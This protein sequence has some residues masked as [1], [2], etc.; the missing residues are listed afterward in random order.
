MDLLEKFIGLNKNRNTT[1]ETHK[2]YYYYI[3]QKQGK[4]TFCYSLRDIVIYTRTDNNKNKLS[5]SVK[6]VINCKSNYNFIISPE[7][8]GN[9]SKINCIDFK[10]NQLKQVGSV[11]VNKYL[12][13]NILDCI[14][15]GYSGYAI[16][17][18]VYDN[19]DLC[20][21][22]DDLIE[23]KCMSHS[24][25]LYI[26][27][28]CN[29]CIIF[30][31]NTE[32]TLYGIEELFT[33]EPEF[34]KINR[35]LKIINKGKKMKFHL[36]NEKI[37]NIQALSKK[38][39]GQTCVLWSLY[40]FD[41]WITRKNK[42]CDYSQFYLD[43]LKPQINFI[44]AK[45]MLTFYEKF[46]EYFNYDKK[47]LIDFIE[48]MSTL[49]IDQKKLYNEN[50]LEIKDFLKLNKNKWA[51]QYMIYD[52]T[53]MYTYLLFK[54][55]INTT[56]FVSFYYNYELSNFIIQFDEFKEKLYS[57]KKI[58]IPLKQSLI[59]IINNIDSYS[60]LRKYIVNNTLVGTFNQIK[61][62]QW[63]DMIYQ[64]Q[65]DS[66]KE[67]NPEIVEEIVSSLSDYSI[68]KII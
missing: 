20:N 59:Y 66:I 50:I 2:L 48:D 9:V 19:I 21:F 43:L 10:N 3:Q 64:K 35:K 1:D 18:T 41:K 17:C 38:N 29:S 13:R 62:A 67:C 36:E 39:V 37:Q 23:K 56:D 40:I 57:T 31:A 53:L 8:R 65:F 6:N 4:K 7:K 33:N 28:K 44:K 60:N 14:N 49:E 42:K 63:K 68:F 55:G 27:F 47:L 24:V 54:Y 46:P 45:K 16:S 12:S 51:K 58:I 32:S 15:N 30:N 34:I 52:K 26:D 11:L 25:I 22:D 61:V 5:K